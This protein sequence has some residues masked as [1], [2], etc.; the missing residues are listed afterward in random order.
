MVKV[1]CVGTSQAFPAYGRQKVSV[2]KKFFIFYTTV[3]M[4]LWWYYSETLD[5]T[6]S[7]G[8]TMFCYNVLRYAT[9]YTSPHLRMSTGLKAGLSKTSCFSEAYACYI[10]TQRL[11]WNLRCWF[12]VHRNI[13][14]LCVCLCEREN[15]RIWISTYSAPHLWSYFL[16]CLLT[17]SISSTGKM[18]FCLFSPS[19]LLAAVG[20]WTQI[21][22]PST[23]TNALLECTDL[24]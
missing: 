3:M 22:K 1:S 16:S 2:L 12:C 19:I 24:A 21:F 23:L 17:F 13:M 8:V 9:G 7:R 11:Q 18:A 15:A 14:L 5:K 10:A 4:Y 6:H 20:F